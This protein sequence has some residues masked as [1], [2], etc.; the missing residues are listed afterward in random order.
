MRPTVVNNKNKSFSYILRS[1][2][3][4]Q[5]IEK[6]TIEN[7]NYVR[8]FY[9]NQDFYKET[10]LINLTN[11]SKHIGVK[12]VFVKD[13][14]KRFDTNA[15]KVIG[16]AYAIS[17]ILCNR[18]DLDI[19]SVDFNILKSHIDNDQNKPTLITATD[20][21]HGK[22]V[23]WVANK[24]NLKAIIY[25]PEGTVDA[26]IENIKNVGGVVNVTNMNYDKT[27]N[28][29]SELLKQNTN[30]ILVQDTAFDNYIDVPVWIMQGYTQMAFEAVNQI[31]HKPTHI[32]LQAGVGAMA[33]GIV[34]FFQNMFGDDKPKIIIVEPN[35]AAC[36]YKTAK[37]GT[38]ELRS[39]DGDLDTIMAGL[40]CGVPTLIGGTI[41]N[42]YAD[43]YI[44]CSDVF[45][46]HGTRML[47]NPLKG[48]QKVISG[49]SGSVC[50]G[51]LY[52]IINTEKSLKKS[53]NIN[54]E[55]EILIIS[56]EGDTDPINYYKILWFDI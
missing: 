54:E 15:F 42:D 35:N 18:Y 52:H 51:V 20:G 49:E 16:A 25:M 46:V 50:M 39:V 6:F 26:R 47:A 53:L 38:E 32:F 31:G 11:Y 24:I 13:E 4:H 41:L 3:N 48:D 23:A 34:G 30:Y 40:A 22:G 33:A 21:N 56:T 19:S 9:N 45:S 44:K 17:R 10:P 12:N 36:I 2:K 7:L 5:D 27:V 43:C 55:S 14:S 29:V 28:H 1:P 37:Y 8:K